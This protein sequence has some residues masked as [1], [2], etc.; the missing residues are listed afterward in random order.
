MSTSE[1]TTKSPPNDEDRRHRGSQRSRAH[2]VTTQPCPRCGV[3]LPAALVAE[4]K[5][6]EQ[7]CHRRFR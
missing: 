2:E 3:S 5:R 4:I 6:G 7:Q 1:F